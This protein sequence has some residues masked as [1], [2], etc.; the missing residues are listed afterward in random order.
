M[1]KGGNAMKTIFSEKY[2]IGKTTNCDIR[3]ICNTDCLDDYGPGGEPCTE[4]T[5]N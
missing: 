3:G 2:Y 4:C 1:Q 5:D